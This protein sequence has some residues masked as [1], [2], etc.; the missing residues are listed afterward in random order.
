[1][2]LLSQVFF[3]GIN[4]IGAIIMVLDIVLSISFKAVPNLV[5]KIFNGIIP[6]FSYSL[7]IK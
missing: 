4:K 2:S 1:M 3:T 5:K 6:I 7:L